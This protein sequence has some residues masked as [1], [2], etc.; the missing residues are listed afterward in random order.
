MGKRRNAHLYTHG[1][2]AAHLPEFQ[3]RYGTEHGKEVYG[4]VV[5]KVRRERMAKTGCHNCGAPTHTHYHGS[6]RCCGNPI[7]CVANSQHAVF[8]GVGGGVELG[9]F[10]IPPITDVGF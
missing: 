7:C 10:E 6:N 5:G 4:A 1:G 9:S 8:E 2:E 3:A